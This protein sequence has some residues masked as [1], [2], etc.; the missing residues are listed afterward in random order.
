MAADAEADGIVTVHT[1]TF[2][3][4][5]HAY[6]QV[7]AISVIRVRTVNPGTVTDLHVVPGSAVAAGEVLARISGPNMQALLTSRE[8]VLRSAQAREKAAGRALKIARS[9]VAAQ[10]ATRQQ[11]NAAQA[12]LAAARAAVQT[13]SVRLREARDLQVVRAPAAGTV[14]ALH[15]SDGEQT[16]VGQTL[17]TLLP[18]GRLWVHGAYYGAD[19]ALLRVGMHGSFQPTGGGANIP[20]KITAI[21]PNLAVDG[22][23]NVGLLPTSPPPP[24]WVSG[25]WGTIALKGPSQRMIPVPTSALVLDRGHWWVMVHTAKGDKPQQVVPGP[26][27]G[28]QTWLQSGLQAGQQIVVQDAFLKYHRGIAQ[29]YQPPD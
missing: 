18:A 17:M 11:V 5:L 7:E 20:V 29:S 19:A 28:W 9:Q 15:A 25:R 21:S 23:R 10:L 1:E 12:D 24:S 26:T 13:A 16:T 6:G 4:S 3:R 2:Q 22:G 8:Q 14:I 27:Q